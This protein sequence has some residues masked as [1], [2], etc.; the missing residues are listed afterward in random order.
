MT[1]SAFDQGRNSKDDTGFRKPTSAADQVLKVGLEMRNVPASNI[2]SAVNL[3]HLRSFI[4]L[5]E[6]LH[7]ARAASRLGLEQSPLSRQIKDLEAALGVRLFNRDSRHTTLTPLGAQFLG[8]A[9]RLLTDAAMSVSALRRGAAGGICYMRVGLAEGAAC[10]RLT[11]VLRMCSA[12]RDP[13]SVTVVERTS[14]ELATLVATGALEAAFVLIRPV[15][16][17]LQTDPVWSSPLLLAV[18]V[19]HAL[20]QQRPIN[21]RALPAERWILPDPAVFPGYSDQVRSLIERYRVT[22]TDPLYAAHHTSFARFV[23]GGSGMA[24]VA[25]SLV[26]A[27]EGVVYLPVEGADADLK[28]WLITRRGSSSPSV[29]RLRSFCASLG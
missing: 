9:R 27:Q 10:G 25:S 14:F 17:D 19:D 23:A 8:D 2:A 26:N 28:V 3:R 29:E 12:G 11:Q 15:G 18:S 7:F 20:A 16:D 24:L 5:A 13:L 22:V 4:V 6:E 21:L 1:S